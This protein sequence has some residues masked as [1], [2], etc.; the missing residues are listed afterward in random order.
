MWV[1]CGK[2]GDGIELLEI[3][4]RCVVVAAGEDVL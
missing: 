1:R 4:E 2:D 3:R